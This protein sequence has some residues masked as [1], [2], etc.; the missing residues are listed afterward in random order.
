VVGLNYY[1]KADQ[2]KDGTEHEYLSSDEGDT[3]SVNDEV[4]DRGGL[5]GVDLWWYRPLG[6]PK[7]V[8]LGDCSG[9][10]Y[11]WHSDGRITWNSRSG[12]ERTSRLGVCM[13][14]CCSATFWATEEREQRRLSAGWR[15]LVLLR[16]RMCGK[17]EWGVLWSRVRGESALRELSGHEKWRWLKLGE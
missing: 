3:N 6:K 4:F 11:V 2:N 10:T 13:D 16:S 9:G 14:K 5:V 17:S 12:M 15:E 7:F 1:Q 8:C